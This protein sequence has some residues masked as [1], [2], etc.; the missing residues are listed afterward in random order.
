MM[1]YSTMQSGRN[2]LAAVSGFTLI[3]AL[4][5]TALMGVILAALASITAQ[6]L[7]NWDR[8]IARAQRSELVSIALNRLVADLGAS[9]FISPNRDTK[10]PLF[11]GTEF[12]VTIVR[13][14]LGPN[15]RPGLEIVRIAETTDKNGKVLVRSIKPFVPLG[16]STT[17]V[18][19]LEF[20]NPVILLRAPYRVSFSYAGRD[21]IWKTTWRNVNELP[22]AVRLTVRD[23]ASDRTLSIS[24]T[25]LIHVDLPAACVGA[26]NNG[27][28]IGRPGEDNDR[29]DTNP[30]QATSANQ[31]T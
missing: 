20:A 29:P 10:S 2:R 25:A 13:S 9:E 1:R 24:T 17:A 12:S 22:A 18:G 31:R 21:G 26:K 15:T 5:A 4:V 23:A 8:G 30:A 16:S 28:C 27:D 6:W 19:Q 14:A 7:P 3:E 11:D